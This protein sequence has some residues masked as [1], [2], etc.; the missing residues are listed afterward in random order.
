ME[1]GLRGPAGD[2]RFCH[3]RSHAGPG[4]PRPHCRRGR[5]EGR[6]GVPYSG[7]LGGLGGG[8]ATSVLQMRKPRPGGTRLVQGHWETRTR[9]SE[10]PA[11]GRFHKLGQGG[12]GSAEHASS[13]S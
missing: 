9:T 1:T 10:Q 11:R 4:A 13:G 6:P 3:P 12:T 8:V 2:K 5:L 7:A